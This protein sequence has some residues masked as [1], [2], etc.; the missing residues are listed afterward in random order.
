M[1]CIIAYANSQPKVNLFERESKR[2]KKTF[3]I[4]EAYLAAKKSIPI[5]SCVDNKIQTS[6]YSRSFENKR[7]T[8]LLLAHNENTNLTLQ[9][10]F[11]KV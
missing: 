9:V 8:E 1:I 7:I 5:M 4:D 10:F 6:G 11:F 3:S 2:G